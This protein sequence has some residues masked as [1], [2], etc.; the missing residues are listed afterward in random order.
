MKKELDVVAALIRKDNKILLCQRGK[1]DKYANLWE[2]PGGCVEKNESYFEAIEREIKE[3]LGFEVKAKRLVSEFFD[4]DRTLKIK[5]FLHECFICSGEPY[6]RD[7]Q[8]FGFF[9]FADAQKLKL[10][11]A[12]KKI[13]RYL[14]Y[15]HDNCR[16]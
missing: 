6:A 8:D 9:T 14:K 2:F 16:Q 12:D 3:E 15:F 10:A 11:P 7:C 1:D 4:E 5:V 13:L